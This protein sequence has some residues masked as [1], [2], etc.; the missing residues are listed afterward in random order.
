[1]DSIS[2]EQYLLMI[3][4]SLPFNVYMYFPWGLA[5]IPCYL[6]WFTG[7]KITTGM[8]GVPFKLSLYIYIF[9]EFYFF[10]LKFIIVEKLF[11]LY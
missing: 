9:L 6:C 7:E 2:Y 10:I 3:Y 4:L 5:A 8:A 1:M 11:A